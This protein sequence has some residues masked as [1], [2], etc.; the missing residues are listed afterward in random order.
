MGSCFSPLLHRA[1]GIPITIVLVLGFLFGA[2]ER[3][4]IGWTLVLA[5]GLSWGSFWVF[6]TLLKCP[7][8]RRLRNLMARRAE[9]V[10]GFFH[11]TVR[12][13][14]LLRLHRLPHRNHGRRPSRRRPLAGISLLLPTTFAW[15]DSGSDPP[16]QRLLR[17]DVRRIDDIHPD[18]DPGEAASVMTCIDGHAMA[19][20]GRAGPALSS[21]HRILHSRHGEHRRP[22]AHGAAPGPV[23]LRSG[24]RNTRPSW[25]WGSSS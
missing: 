1:P 3:M 8:A 10:S 17:G 6:D 14:P 4:K 21:P 12:D 20:N 13:E 2:L 16:M 7:T 19:L 24:R 11:G 18:E 15:S 9:S 5:F 25:S 22:H 23:R